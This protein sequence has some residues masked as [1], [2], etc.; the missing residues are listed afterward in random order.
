MFGFLATKAAGSIKQDPAP[1][2]DGLLEGVDQLTDV[3][4]GL[5]GFLIVIGFLGLVY[6][7]IRWRRGS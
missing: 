2:I 4:I 7:V 5:F 1:L 6:G 3:V